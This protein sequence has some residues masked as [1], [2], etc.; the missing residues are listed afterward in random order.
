MNLQQVNLRIQKNLLLLQ[1]TVSPT[2]KIVGDTVCT[3]APDHKCYPST[4]G[5]PKCC[6]KPDTSDCLSDVEY[7]CE[8]SKST[9]KPTQKPTSKPTH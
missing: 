1:S 7:P 6:E 5:W 4:G 8:V 3:Y 2:F 9:N